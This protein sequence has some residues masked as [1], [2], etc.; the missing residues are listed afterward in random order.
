MLDNRETK[1]DACA[2]D[3]HGPLQLSKAS[4]Q[5]REVLWGDSTPCIL[6]AHFYDFLQVTVSSLDLNR[7]SQS[8][9][10]SVLDQVND[11][12]LEPLTVSD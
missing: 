5:F 6:Y 4:E 2:V 9:F 3:I 1:S 8:E 12:L 7:T 11:N 10:Y